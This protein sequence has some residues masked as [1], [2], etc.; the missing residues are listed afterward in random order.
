MMD[1][2]GDEYW[3]IVL[4]E[5]AHDAREDGDLVTAELLTAAAMEYFGQADRAAAR[6]RNFEARL[7]E[8]TS[9]KPRKAA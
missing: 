5:M 9:R 7:D 8:E 6:W 1:H 4:L 3:G 2:K